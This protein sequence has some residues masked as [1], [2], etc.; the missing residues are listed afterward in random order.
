[1]FGTCNLCA[2]TRSTFARLNQSASDDTL[3]HVRC[4]SCRD[5]RD[6]TIRR[7]ITRG[8]KPRNKSRCGTVRGAHKTVEQV[9]GRATGS[10]SELPDTFGEYVLIPKDERD[11]DGANYLNPETGDKLAL[12]SLRFG[13]ALV[14]LPYVRPNYP[15]AEAYRIGIVP[16]EYR[17]PGERT[18]TEYWRD[19][20]RWFAKN[21][22]EY[23]APDGSA[24]LPNVIPESI[25]VTGSP[26]TINMILHDIGARPAFIGKAERCLDTRIPQVSNGMGEESLTHKRN[27]NR[28]IS[29]WIHDGEQLE[30]MKAKAAPADTIRDMITRIGMQP[31]EKY[32]GITYA[33]LSK[34]RDMSK[35]GGILSETEATLIACVRSGIPPMEWEGMSKA[36]AR[37]EK[38]QAQWK[39]IQSVAASVMFVRTAEQSKGIFDELESLKRDI[40]NANPVG[41]LSVTGDMIGEKGA[42]DYKLRELMEGFYP[43]GY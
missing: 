34:L 2:L 38:R 31:G 30:C 29:Q 32:Y 23:S 40:R 25:I 26:D 36:D 16:A 8:A 20:R 5:S 21:H 12:G 41:S 13:R 6:T 27:R 4:N 28:A 35:T 37:E 22:C 42:T 3:N 9:T 15:S 11:A 18:I 19:A 39:R 43:N 7:N 33:A 17:Q 14:Y 10:R 24:L 1:M